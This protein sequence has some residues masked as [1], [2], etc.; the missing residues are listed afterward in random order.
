MIQKTLDAKDHIGAF[1]AS[2]T[3]P[4]GKSTTSTKPENTNKPAATQEKPPLSDIINLHDF[5]HVASATLSPKAWAYISGA[6]NDNLTRD[7]NHSFLRRIW[8]RPIIMRDVSAV[9][10]KTTLFGCPLDIPVY[11]APTGTVR[12]AGEEGE[13]ALA[14][15]AGSAGI[16]HCLST[17]SS[18]PHD[19]V[20][21]ATPRHAFLQLYVN[22]DRAKSEALVRRAASTGKV[23]AIFVTVDLPVVSKR[24]ADERVK[25]SPPTGEKASKDWKGAGLARQ[26]G[27]F[28]DPSLN[29]SDVSWLRGLTHLPIV[30]KGVQRWEDAVLAMKHG[31][32]G[33]VLSNHGGRAADT[34]PPSVVLLLELHRNCPEVFDE[35]VVLV[36]GGFRRGEDV[37]KAVCLGARAVGVGRPFFYAVNYG[38]DG[39]EHAVNSECLFLEARGGN[40]SELTGVVLK[41]EIETAMRLCGMT[42]LMRDASPDYVNT[43]DIDHHVTKGGHPYA[44]KRGLIPRL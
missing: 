30:I 33:I 15:G 43:S 25:T 10:A 31:C 12:T 28:I 41:D 44:K 7:A 21:E 34:A 40:M 29:W 19:E 11:I 1:E 16:V 26:T 8:L 4:E 24:E 37:V 2:G 18:Y 42:D 13:L 35:M 32:D 22:K 3:S 14:R 36:D 6:A 38:R 20:F 23:K 39:V 9:T 27:S 5:Q 17:P